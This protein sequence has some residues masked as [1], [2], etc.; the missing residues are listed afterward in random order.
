MLESSRVRYSADSPENKRR[1]L[2]MTATV[3]ILKKWTSALNSY[4]K[5]SRHLLLTSDRRDPI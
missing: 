1:R 5:D 3:Q 2:F 4:S